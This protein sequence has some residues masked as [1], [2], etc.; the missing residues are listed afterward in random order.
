[1]AAGG[2]NFNALTFFSWLGVTQYLSSAAVL[3][4]LREIAELAVPGCEI[5]FQFIIPAA[6]LAGEESAL[7]TTLAAQAAAVGEPWLS[8]FEP[9]DLEAHL[10]Q[11]GFE[12][13]FHFGPQQAT[14]R[15]LLGRTDGLRPPAYFR[16]ISAR[17]A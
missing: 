12:K 17:V 2:V 5:V 3:G 15:Y 6:A 4:T 13:V 8:F 14:E 11:M 1:L 16:M 9:G 10:R 7:V